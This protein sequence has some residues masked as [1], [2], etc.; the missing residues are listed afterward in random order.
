[1]LA[2]SLAGFPSFGTDSAD[3]PNLT[4][5]NSTSQYS[6]AQHS[7]EAVKLRIMRICS[8]IP[9]LSCPS[10]LSLDA[11]HAARHI[12]SKYFGHNYRSLLFIPM[13]LQYAS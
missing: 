9:A 12:R 3:V 6:T 10:V 2:V 1:M 11:F 13:I 8:I 7:L 4:R 5:L